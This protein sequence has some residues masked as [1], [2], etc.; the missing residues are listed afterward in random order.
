VRV[1]CVCAYPS[2]LSPRPL[3]PL[4]SGVSVAVSPLPLSSPI[5]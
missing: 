3:V 2:L 4:Y 1:P 5:P